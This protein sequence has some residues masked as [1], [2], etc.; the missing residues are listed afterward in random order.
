MRYP[1]DHIE[2]DNRLAFRVG[3]LWQEYG[4]RSST[5]WVVLGRDPSAVKASYERKWVLSFLRLAQCGI[6]MQRQC[7]TNEHVRDALLTMRANIELLIR[8]QPAASVMRLRLERMP[9]D[10]EFFWQWIGAEGDRDAALAEWSV[11]H[12]AGE[13]R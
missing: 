5:R 4:C 11:L 1:P 9:R 10:F 13:G 7:N 8:S 3:R 12:N 6:T 2:V